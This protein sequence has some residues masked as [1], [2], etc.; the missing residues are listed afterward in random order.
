MCLHRAA[1]TMQRLGC[2]FPDMGAAASLRATV[3]ASAARASRQ[4][5]LRAG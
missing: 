2:D 4:H 1:G 3:P 5:L